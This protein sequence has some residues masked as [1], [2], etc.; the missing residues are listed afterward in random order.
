MKVK[1][2][3]ARK[4]TKRVKNEGEGKERRKDSILVYRMVVFFMATMK[5]AEEILI[6]LLI[7]STHM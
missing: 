5:C 2:R 1:L 6:K 4:C 3:G 7:E